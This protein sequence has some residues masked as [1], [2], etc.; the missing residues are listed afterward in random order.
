MCQLWLH[1]WRIAALDKQATFTHIHTQTQTT[2]ISSSSIHR[3]VEVARQFLT[4]GNSIAMFQMQKNKYRAYS[5]TNYLVFLRINE[6]RC[7]TPFYKYYM[8]QYDYANYVLLSQWIHK[9]TQISYFPMKVHYMLVQCMCFSHA[10]AELKVQ[11]MTGNT[12]LQ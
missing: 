1:M 11:T 12:M 7:L 8:L 5:F 2:H 4:S 3:N 6:N 10:M 9:T